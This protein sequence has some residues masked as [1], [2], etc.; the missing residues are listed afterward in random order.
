MKTGINICWILLLSILYSSAYAGN[1]T[2]LMSRPPGQVITISP[3]TSPLIKDEAEFVFKLSESCLVDLEILEFSSIEVGKNT[4]KAKK[5][6]QLTPYLKLIKNFL[7]AEG[8]HSFK[9]N[10]QITPGIWMPDGTYLF[11]FL[12]RPATKPDSIQRENSGILVIDNRDPVLLIGLTEIDAAKDKGVP[13]KNGEYL[14]LS[15]MVQDDNFY[16]ALVFI[17][18]KPEPIITISTSPKNNE[19]FQTNIDNKIK[20]YIKTD[21]ML[22]SSGTITFIAYDQAGNSAMMRFPFQI[23]RGKNKKGIYLDKLALISPGENEDAIFGLEISE[24]CLDPSSQSVTNKLNISLTFRKELPAGHKVFARISCPGKKAIEIPAI[25]FD[26]IVKSTKAYRSKNGKQKISF[27][28][29]NLYLVK[30]ENISKCF[31]EYQDGEITK[32]CLVQIFI[33]DKKG[34]PVQFESGFYT[35][36]ISKGVNIQKKIRPRDISAFSKNISYNKDSRKLSFS[37]GKMVRSIDGVSGSIVFGNDIFFAWENDIKSEFFLIDKQFKRAIR[38]YPDLTIANI[39]PFPPNLQNYSQIK[40]IHTTVNNRVLIISELLND[41]SIAEIKFLPSATSFTAH[42]LC[43]RIDTPSAGAAFRETVD[44]QAAIAGRSLRKNDNFT[45]EYIKGS[46]PERTELKD[47]TNEQWTDA[48]IQVIYSADEISFPQNLKGYLTAKLF[49]GRGKSVSSKSNP[50]QKLPPGVYTLRLKIFDK[51]GNWTESRRVFEIAETISGENGGIITSSDNKVVINFSP[52]SINP[53]KAAI[54]IRPFISDESRAQELPSGVSQVSNFYI[55]QSKP[56]SLSSST[57]IFFVSDQEFSEKIVLFIN[58]LIKNKWRPAGI[59]A[60]EHRNGKILYKTSLP[61]G[62]AFPAV[63]FWGKDINQKSSEKIPLAYNYPSFPGSGPQYDFEDARQLKW[64]N[65]VGS[66]KTVLS[67]RTARK[68]KQK[69]LHLENQIEGGSFRSIVTTHPFTISSLKNQ[70]L[71]F[72]Y[73]FSPETTAAFVLH[74]ETDG[75]EENLPAPYRKQIAKKGWTEVRLPI[76]KSTTGKNAKPAWQRGALINLYSYLRLVFLQQKNSNFSVRVRRIEFRAAGNGGL[77]AGAWAD[78]DNFRIYSA[79]S[80]IS[81]LTVKFHRPI[82]INVYSDVWSPKNSKGKKPLFVVKKL[83]PLDGIIDIGQAVIAKKLEG[84]LLFKVSESSPSAGTKQKKTITWKLFNGIP[85]Q[86]P[87]APALLAPFTGKLH[88]SLGKINQNIL[89]NKL[90]H[91]ERIYKLRARVYGKFKI[92]LEYEFQSF[93]ELAEEVTV[94]VKINIDGKSLKYSG[95]S[96]IKK[97]VENRIIGKHATAIIELNSFVEDSDNLK[98]DSDQDI[99]N[100]LL[101]GNF[102]DLLEIRIA[103]NRDEIYKKLL[104]HSIDAISTD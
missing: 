82:D 30:W 72:D 101:T 66:D 9:W 2:P 84:S 40:R 29:T 35:S 14:L 22:F 64:K 34:K 43:A 86:S 65:F 70:I 1:D 83:K 4:D 17:N 41:N 55:V 90:P 96:E 75:I 46:Y 56:M 97:T 23:N 32:R 6:F 73:R 89:T 68:T 78:F 54:V 16:K 58:D 99:A 15:G 24:V 49:T 7:Y 50:H 42:E 74:V 19:E 21:N 92:A 57:G 81:P 26:K 103:I 88:F 47:Q 93:D 100:N 18:D 20:A 67:L 63:I 60:V 37:D 59:A 28:P 52:D 71:E 94:D 77:P 61:S 33:K 27:T 31:S 13:D 104:I 45:L 5:K 11:R 53:E 98:A 95:K 80:Q 76:M 25:R 79:V 62:L 36:T 39:L 85:K 8:V 44:I 91:N 51:Y 102:A 10:G 87:D 38:F 48:G 3:R 12:Y 69:F